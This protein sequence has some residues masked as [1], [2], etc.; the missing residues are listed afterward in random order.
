M[1]AS[2]QNSVSKAPVRLQLVDNRSADTMPFWELKRYSMG[3]ESFRSLSK[4]RDAENASISEESPSK[5]PRRHIGNQSFLS[6]FSEEGRES[7]ASDHNPSAS[8]CLLSDDTVN[9]L[10][11]CMRLIQDQ[12]LLIDNSR[13]DHGSKILGCTVDGAFMAR[14]AFLVMSFLLSMLFRFSQTNNIS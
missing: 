13:N 8:N 11:A 12:I 4:S 3:Q 7:I 1:L 9:E 5:Y 6:A 10:E 14:L 2:A